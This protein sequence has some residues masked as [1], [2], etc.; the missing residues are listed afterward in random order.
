MLDIIMWVA[1]AIGA[2][3][4][5]GFVGGMLSG[6]STNKLNRLELILNEEI[7]ALPDLD[8]D[9]AERR[10]IIVKQFDFWE[11]LAMVVVYAFVGIMFGPLAFCIYSYECDRIADAEKQVEHKKWVKAKQ[12]KER[13]AHERRKERRRL[14][15]ARR[16]ANIARRK[17][18]SATMPA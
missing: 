4:I 15:E 13:E 6:L 16:A 9:S 10:G 12:A 1:V 2:W 3:I 17:A 5:L 14:H 11:E 7:I 8:V 18:E